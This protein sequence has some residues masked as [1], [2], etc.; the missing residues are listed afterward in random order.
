MSDDDG[1][2][3]TGTIEAV[4]GA[5]AILARYAALGGKRSGGVGDAAT[6]KWVESALAGH[7]F[8]VERQV[9]DVPW[10]EDRNA[11]LTVGDRSAA[12]LSHPGSPGGVTSGPLA[13]WPEGAE[14]G[15]VGRAVVVIDLPTTRWSSARDR[16][17]SARVEAA[18]TGGAVGAVLVTHGPA[19]AAI[20]LNTDGL[21]HDYDRPVAIIAPAEA[22][23]LFDVRGQAATLDTSRDEGIR[24]AFNLIGRL[25]RGAA[26]TVVLS[27][28]RS[29][30]YDCAGERGSGLAAWMLLVE[31]ASRTLTGF[32]LI[33][34]CATGHELGY[35][36]AALY[37]RTEAPPP[38]QVALWLHIGANAATRDYRDIRGQP[39]ALPSADT[40]RFLAVSS[41]HLTT[42]EACF[43]GSPA[44][45]AP[46]DVA[47][48]AA[49]ELAHIHAAGY[50]PIA[51]VFG[52]HRF[53][54]TMLDDAGCTSAELSADLACRMT[55]FV[56]A[57]LG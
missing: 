52:A 48:G 8:T 19:S 36:G 18:F 6:G 22:G 49:G 23:W 55:K 28:P 27:T 13:R 7:G 26:R 30:W 33:A 12:V 34:F 1:R 31:W 4:A 3:S 15:D 44:L 51:G 37:L 50:A 53:H 14:M 38:D 5:D 43:A 24:P 46:H 9:L 20:A 40:Q 2:P 10:T 21:G 45:E 11:R 29:G 35:C 25:D 42:A 41:A 56:S 39:L 17:I 47:L 16:R 54:H 32:N 57:V